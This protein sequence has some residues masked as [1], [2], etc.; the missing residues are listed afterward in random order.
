[1]MRKGL[2][3][4]SGLGTAMDK[5]IL[6]NLSQSVL[7]GK[8]QFLYRINERCDIQRVQSYYVIA[9]YFAKYYV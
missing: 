6:N 7:Y 9:K 8:Q 2:F 1:M 3:R 5:G 4:H